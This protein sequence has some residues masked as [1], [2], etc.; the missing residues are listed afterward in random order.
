MGTVFSSGITFSASTKTLQ[1]QTFTIHFASN[2][3]CSKL[4]TSK[5]LISIYHCG[6]IRSGTPTFT[7]SPYQKSTSPAF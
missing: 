2:I 6:S 3:P 5:I 4:V 1:A 7:V